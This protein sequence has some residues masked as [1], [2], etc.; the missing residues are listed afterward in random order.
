LA[1]VGREPHLRSDR[2]VRGGVELVVAV[3]GVL[4]RAVG[5]R[6]GRV[7]ARPLPPRTTGRPL[8]SVKAAPRSLAAAPGNNP[9]SHSCRAWL[10]PVQ[11]RG[12]GSMIRG[13]SFWSLQL[14]PFR[15][16][17]RAN[18]GAA[19]L[20]FTT[21]TVQ[22]IAVSPGLTSSALVRLPP[23]SRSQRNTRNRAA[24]RF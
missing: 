7:R 12:P 15:I 13:A 21:W 3:R 5:V 8:P 6:L 4:D 9:P 24:W 23:A 17:D 1:V 14:A 18:R 20:R 19:P 11:A 2:P 10:A 16:P 22:V